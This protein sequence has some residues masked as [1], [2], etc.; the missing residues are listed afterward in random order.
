MDRDEEQWKEGEHKTTTVGK[1]TD[2][3][4]SIHYR[5]RYLNT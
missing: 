4:E 1:L 5:L 2:V 3:N